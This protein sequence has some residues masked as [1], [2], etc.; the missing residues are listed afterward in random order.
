MTKL[1][2]FALSCAKKESQLLVKGTWDVLHLKIPL[3]KI[4]KLRFSAVKIPS[5]RA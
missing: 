2:I 3:F 4:L 5:S 1:E